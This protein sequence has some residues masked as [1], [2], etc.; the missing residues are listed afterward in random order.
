[1]PGRKKEKM[2]GIDGWNGQNEH[3]VLGGRRNGRGV[4]D[5]TIGERENPE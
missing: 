4:Y 2:D 5:S 3:V 1:M